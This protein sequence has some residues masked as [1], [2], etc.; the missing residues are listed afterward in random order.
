MGYLGAWNLHTIGINLF[1]WNEIYE[2]IYFIYYLYQ[3][4]D[5]IWFL[6]LYGVFKITKKHLI[7]S[8]I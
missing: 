1:P 2:N 8:M 6:K 3:Y 4:S 7:Y 5:A